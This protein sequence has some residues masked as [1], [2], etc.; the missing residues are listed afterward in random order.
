MADEERD[1]DAAERALGTETGGRPE[2]AAE[3]TAR[4]DWER[5][6]APLLSAVPPVEP[7]E[8]LFGR[9]AGRIA[10]E[11][12]II[13]LDSARK[14]VSRW[15]RATALAGSIAAAIAIYVAVDHIQPPAA[16]RYVA[17]VKSDANG[18]AGLIVQF[19]T[20][21]GVATIVPVNI[22]APAGRSLE[23]WHLPSGAT[24]PLSLGLLP[25]TPEA[26]QTLQAGPG[27]IFAISLEPPGGSPTGQPTQP[28]YHGNIVKVE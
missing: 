26:L 1:L 2:S 3:R 24:R 4:E 7:P 12:M 5:R 28:I 23:M 25:D 18:Q 16:E 11:D 6:L 22:E 19:D 14:R 21:T 10:V 27:D 20:G 8:G 15:K 17:V 9:I 13:D